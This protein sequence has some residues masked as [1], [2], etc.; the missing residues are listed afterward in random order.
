M[1]KQEH[2]SKWDDLAREIGAEI[3]PEIER[4][5]EAVSAGA[6][7]PAAQT[8]PAET[9]SVPL[10]PPP[11]RAAVDWNNLAG[12]L[13]L[14]APPASEKSTEKST[15]SPSEERTAPREEPR[16]QR[17][18]R[19]EPPRREQPR[20]EQPRREGSQSRQQ[21]R[22]PRPPRGEQRERGER[23]DHRRDDRGDNRRPPREVDAE[24][25]PEREEPRRREEQSRREERSPREERPPREAE[26]S[27]QRPERPAPVREEPPKP[28][29][30][31][32][33][34]KIFGSPAEPT[35]KPADEAAA[36]EAAGPFDLRDEPRDADS[37]FARPRAGEATVDERDDELANREGSSSDS[38]DGAASDRGRGRPRRRRG[39][40]G[41]GRR[42]ESPPAEGRSREPRESRPRTPKRTESADQDLD[43][44]LDKDLDKDLDDELDADD[45]LGGLDSD[46]DDDGDS[47]EAA[48]GTGAAR[49][50]SV[51]QRAIPTWDEAIGFIVESNMQSRSQRR[52]PPRSGSRDNGGRGRPRGRRRPQ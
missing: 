2:K 52:P 16:Q 38:E 26:R 28:A 15:E 23:S 7:S 10:A 17:E 8:R 36:P 50:R 4:R 41:R 48:A 24:R 27:E 1:E 31:S 37:G 47:D 19:D 13:G 18:S 25:E 43:Q 35:S 32:L 45:I 34:H 44:D 33:W 39:R 49:G 5:E 42:S 14:P 29:S 30:V 46:A 51:L 12:E 3:S 22:P 40:G 9:P 20:R 21:D 11:K 6:E